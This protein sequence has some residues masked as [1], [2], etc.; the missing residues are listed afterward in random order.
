METVV[1]RM[2]DVERTRS[3]AASG[4]VLGHAEQ[5]GALRDSLEP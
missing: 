3:P 5:I 1:A 2:E 4:W